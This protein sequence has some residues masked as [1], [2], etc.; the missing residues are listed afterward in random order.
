M[1]VFAEYINKAFAIRHIGGNIVSGCSVIPSMFGLI[2]PKAEASSKKR[3]Q[4]A[5][6]L[7]AS[8]SSGD[9]D[10][11]EDDDDRNVLRRLLG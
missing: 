2:L 10:D 11:D 4:S 8:A 6:E 9:D 5:A 7:P 1:V 3:K